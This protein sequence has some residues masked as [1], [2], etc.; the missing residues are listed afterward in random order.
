MQGGHSVLQRQSLAARP[1]FHIS[2]LGFALGPQ[3]VRL[4]MHDVQT[5]RGDAIATIAGRRSRRCGGSRRKRGRRTPSLHLGFFYWGHR[6]FTPHIAVSPPWLQGGNAGDAAAAAGGAAGVPHLQPGLHALG[7]QAVRHRLHAQGHQERAVGVDRGAVCGPR[8]RRCAT[9]K[10]RLCVS[11]FQGCGGE[12]SW[13]VVP[14][15][16]LHVCSCIE[17]G[18]RGGRMHAA[19]RAWDALCGSARQRLDLGDRGAGVTSVG[20]HNLSPG[21]VLTDL[22]LKVR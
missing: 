20:V 22:L 3:A 6:L 16:K 14:E 10:Q 19:Y 1:A 15:V 12:V 9:T 18:A 7:A 2:I 13:V 21:M 4:R 11:V 8:G 17:S 5:T